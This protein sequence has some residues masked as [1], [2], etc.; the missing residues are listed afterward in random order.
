[1]KKRTRFLLALIVFLVIAVLLILHLSVPKDDFVLPAQS[2]SYE[3]FLQY[4]QDEK[5]K[6][7]YYEK[8]KAVLYGVLEGSPM[9]I[10]HMPKTYDF[11]VEAV[12]EDALAW[13]VAEQLQRETQGYG[14]IFENDTQ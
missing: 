7:L 8:E 2:T 3:T 6:A 10:D 12:H 4:M 13:V 1:M 14:F 5:V 11:F 9:S